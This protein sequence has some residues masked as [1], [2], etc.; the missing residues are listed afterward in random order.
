MRF[1]RALRLS[2]LVAA[3]AGVTGC[4]HDP[5]APV[6][7]LPVMTSLTVS[8]ETSLTGLGQTSKL[9][10]IGHYADGSSKDVSAAVLWS[11]N[12]PSVVT[13]SSDG[14][15]TTVG[16]GAVNVSAHR[17]PFLESVL[18][19]VTPP[20]TLGVSGWAREPGAGALAGV[21]VVEAASGLSV[22]TLLAGDFM[23][24]F[25][26]GGLTNGH[27]TFTKESFEDAQFDVTASDFIDVPLQRIIRVAAGGSVSSQIAPHDMDYLVAPDTRCGPCRLVR[28]TGSGATLHFR[29][30]WTD[31]A[32]M[33]N[34]WINGQMF[35]GDAAT[36]AVEAD[37]PAGPG[38]LLVYVAKVPT[39]LAD[40]HVAFTFSTTK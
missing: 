19:T 30:A 23:G 37:A 40:N 5:I 36:L 32:S 9:A 18:L 10:A 24:Y 14:T 28:V 7:P 25:S 39:N 26:L 1:L 21:H 6:V 33:F 3:G 4:S 2:I 38:E 16:L 12:A 8:G 35:P 34:V 27:L 11:T 13:V 31:R 15:V 17:Q 22:E 20:G 29:L